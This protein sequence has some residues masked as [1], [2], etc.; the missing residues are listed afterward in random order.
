MPLLIVLTAN[1]M[2]ETYV[3]ASGHTFIDYQYAGKFSVLNS[4]KM[5]DLAGNQEFIE[6][7]K[8]APNY[9]FFAVGTYMFI[10]LVTASL[11][12]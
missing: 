8:A 9:I 11:G 5:S 10:V 6:F 12:K 4:F 3:I 2:F 1:I 7:L